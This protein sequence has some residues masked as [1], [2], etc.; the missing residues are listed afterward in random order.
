M[1]LKFEFY[2]S[3][4]N[5]KFILK[6]DDDKVKYHHSDRHDPKEFQ[7][8]SGQVMKLSDKQRKVVQAF[9]DLAGQLI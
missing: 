2:D 5:E 8:M 7:M 9:Y 6:N 3:D 1:R 4:T